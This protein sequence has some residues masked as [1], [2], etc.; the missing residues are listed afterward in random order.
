MSDYGGKLANT[1]EELKAILDI[2]VG[3]GVDLFH[4]S[5][6]R[7]WEPEFEGSDDNLAA[8][9]KKLS[10]KPCITVGSV[11]LD[12]DFIETFN[13]K[14]TKESSGYEDSIAKVA[15]HIGQDEFDLVAIGRGL[16]S[17]PDWAQLVKSGSAKDLKPYSK[18][19]LTKLY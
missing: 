12:Q 8:W 10:G 4:C 15:Q 19:D 1:P 3:A 6:R 13:P 18:D 5:T 7:F 9:T 16:I 11:G 14:N 17:N 2:L